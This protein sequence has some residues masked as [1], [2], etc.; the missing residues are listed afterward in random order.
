MPGIVADKP[1]GKRLAQ[2]SMS[3]PIIFGSFIM[4]EDQ[5]SIRASQSRLNSPLTDGHRSRKSGRADATGSWNCTGSRGGGEVSAE[6]TV[7]ALMLLGTANEKIPDAAP[8]MD[9]AQGE[10]GILLVTVGRSSAG[11]PAT[12]RAADRIFSPCRPFV[13]QIDQVNSY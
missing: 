1:E 3:M 4:I 10:R 6:A 2:H 13:A 11:R 5:D 9:T 8:V 7:F 12:D